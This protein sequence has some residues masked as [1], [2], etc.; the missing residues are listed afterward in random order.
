MSGDL[1]TLI[2]AFAIGIVISGIFA[3]V[4]ELVTNT[5]SMLHLPATSDGRRLLIV[6]VLVF[7][8]PH[9]VM[10]AA[11]RV[12]RDGEMAPAHTFA[13][14]GLCS[15]WSIGLGFLVYRVLIF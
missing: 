8:A 5:Q 1:Q 10:C 7:A 9:I 13:I 2:F 12:W 15:L 14:C 6:M 4:F 11:G 3:N